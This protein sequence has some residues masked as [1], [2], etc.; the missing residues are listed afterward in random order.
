MPAYG[1]QINFVPGDQV[2]YNNDGTVKD[3][4]KSGQFAPKP[5]HCRLGNPVFFPI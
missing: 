3:G 1:D 5:I 4:Y 2:V